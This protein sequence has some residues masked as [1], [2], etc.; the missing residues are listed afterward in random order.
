VSTTNPTNP[1]KTGRRPGTT[2][3]REAIAQA[4]RTLFAEHGYERATIR[5]IAAA[6][7]VDPALVVHFFGSK[8][9]LF[10]EVMALPEA[11]GDLMAQIAAGERST[12]GRRLAQLIV[13]MLEN[14]AT[15]AIVLGRIRSAATHPDAAAL[16][17]E[18]VSR[19]LLRLATAL[20]T[21]NAEMRASLVGSHL[22]G[23]AFARYIV[24]VEP[25]VSLD[26]AALV[27]LLADDFQRCLVEPLPA[28]PR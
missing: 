25:L 26:A 9:D 20:G 11:V 7:G 2:Q 13:G 23:V 6:A 14:P 3:T 5:R 19:D 27:A 1:K 12:V 16:V 21:D 22:V 28:V 18:T 8:E 17:R 10:S 15:R 4:A 24:Q